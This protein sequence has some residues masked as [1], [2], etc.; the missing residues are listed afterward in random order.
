LPYSVPKCTFSCFWGLGRIVPRYV[1]E[2]I[3]ELLQK[4]EYKRRC[5]NRDIG[6]SNTISSKE[7]RV[8]VYALN[9]N[10]LLTYKFIMNKVI[11]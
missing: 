3:E 1:V 9:P 6:C 4:D 8:G 10:V 11:H 7:L 5:P 2:D